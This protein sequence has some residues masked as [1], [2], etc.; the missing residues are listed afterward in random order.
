MFSRQA[1]CVR[2]R[3]RDRAV[4][5]GYAALAHAPDTELRQTGRC[6]HVVDAQVSWQ[7]AD[8]RQDVVHEICNVLGRKS[9]VCD[10]INGDTDKR[11]TGSNCVSGL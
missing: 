6:L 1:Q 2:N 8:A 3:R 10:Q 9:A 4:T 11:R 7:V 5:T